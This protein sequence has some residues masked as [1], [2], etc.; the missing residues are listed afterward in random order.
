[1]SSYT[2]GVEVRLDGIYAFRYV[3][4]VWRLGVTAGWYVYLYIYYTRYYVCKSCV[5][6]DQELRTTSGWYVYLYIYNLL[7]CLQEQC[8]EGLEVRPDGMSICIPIIPVSMPARA[9]C[10]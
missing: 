6:V 3:K 9:V 5:S 10:L 4:Y 2:V 8:V 1:M 7:V